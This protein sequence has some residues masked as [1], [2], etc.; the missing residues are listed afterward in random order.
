MR[1]G[2]SFIHIFSY[3]VRACF[4][5][6]IFSSFP[7]HSVPQTCPAAGLG[8]WQSPRYAIDGEAPGLRLGKQKKEWNTNHYS[9]IRMTFRSFP[10]LIFV[11]CILK[12]PSGQSGG[13][14]VGHSFYY[15][16]SY[17]I[18]ELCVICGIW[19]DYKNKQNGIKE[20][21]EEEESG[22]TGPPV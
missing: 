6:T 13:E 4:L 15:C 16:I 1:C 21:R 10:L 9:Q 14:R 17:Q 3:T 18:V 2:T 8:K 5:P 12:E 19:M 11:T 7:S 20:N 22:V